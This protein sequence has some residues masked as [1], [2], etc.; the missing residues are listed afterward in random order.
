MDE[1][2]QK[3]VNPVMLQ[4]CLEALIS[5]AVLRFKPR[6]DVDSRDKAKEKLLHE[7][8]KEVTR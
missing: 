5:A 2:T 4:K 1:C 7:L 8:N 6:G 3:F